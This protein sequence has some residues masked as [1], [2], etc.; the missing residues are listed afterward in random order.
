MK[1]EKKR[2]DK[3]QF[4]SSS[5][6]YSTEFDSA[7]GELLYEVT[8]MAY[9]V[10]AFFKQASRAKYVAGCVPVIVK[11]NWQFIKMDIWSC[12]LPLPSTRRT[13]LSGDSNKRS[14]G[15]L[16]ELS[17]TLLNRGNSSS[18][19]MKTF[20][21]TLFGHF[22]FTR[23]EPGTVQKRIQLWDRVQVLVLAVARLSRE[24]GENSPSPPTSFPPT[25]PKPSCL[26]ILGFLLQ[27][28]P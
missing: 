24:L 11:A 13:L 4:E 9:S 16:K 8:H 17:I 23:E 27:E 14:N 1:K 22:D 15:R 18:R 19:S 3:A 10:G 28:S 26:A 25:P 2:Y 5:F 6:K 20:V 12:P 21:V 7:R